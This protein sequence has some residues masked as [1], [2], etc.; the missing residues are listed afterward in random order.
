LLTTA[1]AQTR[2]LALGRRLESESALASDA[3]GRVLAEDIVATRDAPAF[4][5]S[6]MDGY[7]VRA[8]DVRAHAPMRVA[9][10]ARAGVDASDLVE[11]DACRIFTGAPLPRGADAVIMQEDADR[12]GDVVRFRAT[13][14]SGAF[15]RRRGE[16]L[17]AGDVALSRG[18]RIGP[19]EL[20]LLASLEAT[21]VRAAR[22]PC[23]IILPTGDEL[24]TTGESA[25]NASIPE[26]NSVAIAAMATRA[27]AK[28]ERRSPVPDD[29]EKAR[30]AIDDAL[31]ACDVLVTIGGVSVGDHDVVRAALDACGVSL[32]FWRVALKPGKPLAVGKRGDSIV[33]GLPGNPVSAMIT[34]ALFGVPLLRA[35]QGDLR[36]FPRTSRRRLA[37]SI[38]RSAGRLELARARID[39]RGDVALVA[40]QASGAI[41]GLSRADVLACIPM[42][43]THLDAGAEIDVYARE[44][45]GL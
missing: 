9:F 44:E 31:G 12:E 28:A 43:A 37:S 2:V 36:P 42:D 3:L 17:R 30:A 35:M 24:R 7:A 32:D 11:G 1:E 26:S 23:V 33:L 39:E 29:L 38:T 40:Q 13:T 25:T 45:L 27:F 34:F 5:A 22:A 8:A 18:T 21:T 16:D 4:D 10:E 14:T 41:I 19:V 15:V 20:A 6:T